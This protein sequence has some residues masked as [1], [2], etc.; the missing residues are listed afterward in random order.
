MH[1]NNYCTTFIIC[2]LTGHIIVTMIVCDLFCE[3]CAKIIVVVFT[4]QYSDKPFQCDIT[5]L[6]Q[7]LIS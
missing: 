5:R 4:S 2:N 3:L 1:T 7:W 6:D